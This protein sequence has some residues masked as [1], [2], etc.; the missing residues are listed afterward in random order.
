MK[1]KSSKQSKLERDSANERKEFR[2]LFPSC[3]ICGKHDPD[4]HTI[5]EIVR[6]GSRS[7]GYADRVAWLPACFACNCG[8][9]N[10][11]PVVQK[12][13][14]KLCVD[15]EYFDLM[16]VNEMRGRAPNAITLTD[17]ATYLTPLIQ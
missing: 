9:L 6:G 14:I 10:S 15:P 4:T 8:P 13:A 12:L 17:V 11:M 16:K 7:K 5:D 2:I 1:R 3:C